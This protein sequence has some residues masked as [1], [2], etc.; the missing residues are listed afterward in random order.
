M[1]NKVANIKKNINSEAVELTI[2]KMVEQLGIESQILENMKAQVTASEV[3]QKM[4]SQ[5]GTVN[6]LAGMIRL[7][8]PTNPI[9]GMPAPV[10]E[11]KTEEIG[12]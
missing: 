11:E 4:I 3:Y 7:L 5:Q 1:S 10:V 12:E 2:A 6:G 9:F 8:D